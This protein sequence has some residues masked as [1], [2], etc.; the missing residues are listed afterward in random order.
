MRVTSRGSTGRSHSWTAGPRTS[1]CS[2][3]TV[4]DL[5]AF[6]LAQDVIYVG[7]GNRQPSR[8]LACPRPGPGAAQGVG[9][10]GGHVRAERRDELL[11]RAVRHRLVRPRPTRGAARRPRPAPR[12]RMPPLRRRGAAAADVHAAGGGRRAL[13]MA[14]PPTTAPGWCSPAKELVEV[15]TSRPDAR[16]FRVERTPNGG[17]SE[18]PLTA[19]YLG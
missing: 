12:Q 9:A 19:R 15:V 16:A 2:K 14:G 17:V 13:R 4:A 11:V 1:G 6:V 18:R 8:R 5:E 10:G 7:G 3:R